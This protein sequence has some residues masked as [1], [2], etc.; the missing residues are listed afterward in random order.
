[1][2]EGGCRCGAVRYTVAVAALPSVYCCHCRDCQT[3][4]GSAF[5]QQ[6]PMRADAIAA[7]GPVVTFAMQRDDGTTST[8]YVCGTCHTRLWNINSK[9]PGLA[10]LRAGT[11][12]DS[13]DLMPAMHIWTSRKQAWIAIDPALR[14]FAESAPPA[15]FMAL[16]PR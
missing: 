3:W 5:T 15:N 2:I 6:A 13:A 14:S 4:S 10:V 8:Q 12:D 16:M 1:M 11:L 9:W 7:T